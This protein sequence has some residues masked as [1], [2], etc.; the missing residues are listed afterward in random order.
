MEGGNLIVKT[1]TL[2]KLLIKVIDNYCTDPFLVETFLV[3]HT[4]VISAIELLH[5]FAELYFS[6][7]SETDVN[8]WK[9]SKRKHIL[10]VIVTRLLFF[11]NFF[12]IFIYFILF[13]FV[14]LFYFLTFKSERTGPPPNKNTN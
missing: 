7:K 3:M 2:Q 5:K 13:I 9:Y 10:K 14:Y 6:F 12:I 1:S 11:F 4:Y 8:H